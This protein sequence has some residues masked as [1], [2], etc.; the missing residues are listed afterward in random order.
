M[1]GDLTVLVVRPSGEVLLQTWSEGGT[2]H[3]F[4]QT[5][6]GY[7]EAINGPDWTAYCNEE[8]KLQNL[9][10]NDTADSV[11]RL[12]GWHPLPFDF[13]V[14]TVVFCGPPDGMGNDTDVPD[15]VV[16]AFGT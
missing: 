9:P 5:V 6:G 12:L 2:L 7:I 1:T 10:P 3:Q 4:Q 8:G 11:A 14:G 16:A 13:L 15:F